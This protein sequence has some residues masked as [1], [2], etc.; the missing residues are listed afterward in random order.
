M[1]N[2]DLYIE[3]YYALLACIFNSKIS[4][5][6]AVKIMT[7][8]RKLKQRKLS[9]GVIISNVITGEVIEF[10]RTGKAAEFLGVQ[11]SFISV[12]ALKQHI[13]K[14]TYRIKYVY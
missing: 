7:E 6:R 13:Y 2:N 9:K 5:D 4:A 3:N 1:L 8:P 14:G 11:S 10:D 12:Y